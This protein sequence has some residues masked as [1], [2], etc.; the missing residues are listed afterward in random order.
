[1]DR[2]YSSS[3]NE[4]TT[5]V[6]PRTPFSDITNVVYC[7]MIT[8]RGQT[9]LGSQYV[10]NGS[11]SILSNVVSDDSMTTN[12]LRKNTT[13]KQSVIGNFSENIGELDQH[14]DT[15]VDIDLNEATE[16]GGSMEH[17]IVG[18]TTSQIINIY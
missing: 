11:P 6:T 16:T 12:G 2:D 4:P 5:S 10:D 13:Q 7:R 9:I 8:S 18:I 14:N 17:D 3:K 1:M 15:F